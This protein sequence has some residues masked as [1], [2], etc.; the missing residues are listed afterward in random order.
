MSH[1]SGAILSDFFKLSYIIKFLCTIH[2]YITQIMHLSKKYR[3]THLNSCNFT[4]G[5]ALITIISLVQ[6]CM[7]LWL[8]CPIIQALFCPIFSLSY[9][10]QL[11]MYYP[12]IH[13]SNYAFE[14]KVR[15]N[16]LK[17]MQLYW[18]KCTNYYNFTSACC[19]HLWL[20]RPITQ[21][22]F[23]PI[24]LNFPTSYSF[25]CSIYRYITHIMHL[26]RKY[27]KTHLNSCNY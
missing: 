10:I 13:Y 6:L 8:K 3:K 4:G 23:C 25:I 9:I 7:H 12:Q 20:K 22:L 19:M 16:A 18:R 26:G 11:Y 21:L 17:L 14:S 24:F 2:R 27:R 15:K 1:N 5:S